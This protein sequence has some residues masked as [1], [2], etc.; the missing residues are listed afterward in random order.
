[1]VKLPVAPFSQVSCPPQ[2]IHTKG[3]ILEKKNQSAYDLPDDI[4]IFKQVNKTKSGTCNNEVLSPKLQEVQKDEDQDSKTPE[5]VRLEQNIRFLQDQHQLM[6]A[7]LHGEIESLKARNRGL[8]YKLLIAF[9]KLVLMQIVELQFQLIF[10]KSSQTSS[11][12]G[13][14]STPDEDLKHKVINRRKL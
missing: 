5:Q 2:Y 14:P 12:S 4:V 10:G 7:G 9:T 1:M 3:E 8:S 6:L 13:S 11:S